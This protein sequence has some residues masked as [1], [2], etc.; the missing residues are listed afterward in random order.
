MMNAE[1]LIIYLI[2]NINNVIHLTLLETVTKGVT[3]AGTRTTEL[4]SRHS[5]KAPSTQQE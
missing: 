3:A 4:R 5:D 1:L 2:R